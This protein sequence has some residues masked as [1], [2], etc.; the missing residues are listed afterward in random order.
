M[1]CFLTCNSLCL[2][3]QGEAWWAAVHGVGY[4]SGGCE[5]VRHDLATIPYPM[6]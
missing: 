6:S 2:M 1:T 4:S 5:R 3:S